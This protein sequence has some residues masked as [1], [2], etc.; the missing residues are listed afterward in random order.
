MT[1]IKL[2]ALN[3]FALV[4]TKA[5][6]TCQCWYTDLSLIVLINIKLFPTSATIN[7]SFQSLVEHKL[8]LPP[9]KTDEGRVWVSTCSLVHELVGPP[10]IRRMSIPRTEIYTWSSA[11][12]WSSRGAGRGY[13]HCQDQSG[14]RST[15]ATAHGRSSTWGVHFWLVRFSFTLWNLLTTQSLQWLLFTIQTTYRE[16]RQVSNNLLLI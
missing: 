6:I 3:P 9:S 5:G 13:P 16:F 11:S 7:I 14:K 10:G 2:F 1:W 12:W 8:G 15:P 4:Q